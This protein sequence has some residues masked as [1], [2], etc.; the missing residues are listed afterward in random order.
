LERLIT[1]FNVHSH[2]HMIDL[3]LYL[4]KSKQH[5]LETVFQVLKAFFR[6]QR[7]RQLSKAI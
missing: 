4:A 2:S 3:R 6:L 7:C 5:T 1:F